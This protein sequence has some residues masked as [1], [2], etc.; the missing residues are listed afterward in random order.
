MICHGIR[1]VVTNRGPGRVRRIRGLNASAHRRVRG[2]ALHYGCAI[3]S[4][5][6]AAPSLSLLMH[7]R[8]NGAGTVEIPA[9][10]AENELEF[11][12]DMEVRMSER[13]RAALEFMCIAVA[14]YGE[15]GQPPWPVALSSLYGAFL[16]GGAKSARIL[17]ITFDASVDCWGP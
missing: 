5:A 3:L 12:W 8:R 4:L 10:D 17:A 1:E 9:L 16:A 2:K 14:I 15:S 13:A 11:V 7:S 6:V